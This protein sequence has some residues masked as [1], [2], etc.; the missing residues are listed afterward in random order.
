MRH[1][2]VRWTIE[3]TPE[4]E[5]DWRWDRNLYFKNVYGRYEAWQDAYFDL[6]QKNSETDDLA[7][8]FNHLTANYVYDKAIEIYAIEALERTKPELEV[9][10][11]GLSTDTAL[12]YEAYFKQRLNSFRPN[13]RFLR[14]IANV[15][16]CVV[17]A[18]MAI[19]WMFSHL[20][21]R[22][23]PEEVFCIVD[24]LGNPQE[25]LL[26]EELSDG[27]KVVSF[28]R[29]GGN[30]DGPRLHWGSGRLGLREFPSDLAELANQIWT[31]WR[32]H[33]SLAPRHFSMVANLPW[34]AIR[35]RGLFNLCR[36]KHFIGRDEYNS[37][38]ILRG[39][40]LSRIGAKSHGISGAVYAAYTDVAPNSRYVGYDHLYVMGTNVIIAERWRKSM[41]LHPI[42]TWGFPREQL[43]GP[44]PPGND[45]L[46]SVRIAFETEEMIRITH[47]IADAFPDKTIL[48]QMKPVTF[49]SKA[50][51]EK[52]VGV[53]CGDH[54]NI[55]L[56]DAPI[57]D[58]VNQAKYHI[59]DISSV[60]AESI[61]RGAYCFVADVLGHQSCCYR[62]FP[63]LCVRTAS[64]AVSQI[65]KIERG[66]TRYRR[67]EYMKFLGLPVETDPFDVIRYWVG[68][69]P[70]GFS[71]QKPEV[72]GDKRPKTV[73]SS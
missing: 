72:S 63:E 11:P 68:L 19:A 59:S 6:P 26:I 39:G 20:R 61:H 58:L 51:L 13:A 42:G 32:R 7:Y 47:A 18:T 55:Q 27:G 33:G 40:E 66:E 67:E 48:L 62:D 70:R 54:E 23:S 71:G 45:V 8:A 29:S 24:R 50:E 56:S 34:K 14:V 5:N 28:D 30:V 46:I 22:T 60:V 1:Y 16:I 73:S 25:E 44:I 64:E 43:Q 52:L 12:L 15:T 35:W 31:V 21:L 49:L 41:G 69:P 2:R 53:Y 37:D 10:K 65:Q 9:N 4:L 57:Y 36:P 38:H 17:T 3:Y